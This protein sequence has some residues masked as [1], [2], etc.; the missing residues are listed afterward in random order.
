MRWLYKYPQRAFP[1][2]DL[3]DENGRRG[4]HDP[5]YELVDTGVFDDDRY[6]DVELTYAKAAP[7]DM[8]IQIAVTNRGPDP[9]PLHVL[10]T[11]W[12]RNT[13]SWGRDDRRPWLEMDGRDVGATHG[14]LGNFHLAAEGIDEHQWLFC[15]NETN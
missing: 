7:D 4:V 3:V 8:C 11:L 2:A 12:F 13:W 5:E 10:P 1:Y 6:F 14:L 9:A 15:E